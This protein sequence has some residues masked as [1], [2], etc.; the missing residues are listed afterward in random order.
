MHTDFNMNSLLDALADRAAVRLRAEV[1][2]NGSGTAI[3]PR[4]LTLGAC[5]AP[6]TTGGRGEWR[7]SGS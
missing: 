3:R 6:M 4:L 2:Q 7:H 1:E 5:I